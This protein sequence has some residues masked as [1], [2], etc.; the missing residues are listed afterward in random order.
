MDLDDELRRMFAAS[1]DK[2][3]VPVRGDAEQT[4]V[5]G[6]QRRRKR[7]LAAVTAGGAAAVVTVVAVGI[8]LAL[9]NQEAMPPALIP[10]TTDS[11]PTEPSTPPPVAPPPTAEA[12]PAA[13]PT[14]GS[15]GTPEDNSPEEPSGDPPTEPEVTG[16]Q[17]GPSGFLAL[18]LGMSVE[19]AMATGMV[20]EGTGETGCAG[21]PLL[22]DGQESG[23]A[24]FGDKGLQIIAP[25][26]AVHTVD[27]VSVGWTIAEFVARYPD[28]QGAAENGE[29]YLAVPGNSGAIYRVI[30]ANDQ[31][32]RIQLQMV[33]MIC[34]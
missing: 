15:T 12:P 34:D 25:T 30:F 16:Q 17:L 28:E 3:D 13:P 22:I 26:V 33:D 19:S 23:T 29:A 5:A 32:S 27:G 2:L 31:I 21:R 1:G 24:Y 11:T 10:T 20:G 7:R 4:I 14:G 18:E 6:A 8:A 9:P